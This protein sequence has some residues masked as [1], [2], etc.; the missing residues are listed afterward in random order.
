MPIG[1]VS[2]I[3]YLASKNANVNLDAP[4]VNLVPW[5]SI[6][7][8]L[9]PTAANIRVNLDPNDMLIFDA[10]IE[11]LQSKVANSDVIGFREIV[12]DMD[13]WVEEND[14]QNFLL[15]SFITVLQGM[16][17]GLQ[18]VPRVSPICG[19]VK[20]LHA[21]KQ[22]RYLEFGHVQLSNIQR[23]CTI[24]TVGNL[25]PKS[26][27]STVEGDWF[28][29]SDRVYYDQRSANYTLPGMWTHRL[30]DGRRLFV[31]HR[32]STSATQGIP[33]KLHLDGSENCPDLED[34][35]PSLAT[36]INRVS[37][38]LDLPVHDG[39]KQYKPEVIR[40]TV[41][42]FGAS[43]ILCHKPRHHI[44]DSFQSRWNR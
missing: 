27:R 39:M 29:R 17:A 7:G 15:K 20:I 42:S 16:A 12:E 5:Q 13:S 25:I 6:E 40:V 34:K 4:N 36:E 21:P 19:E 18:I 14:I 1:G 38:L 11:D 33:F 3:Q 2:V 10:F 43:P 41:D 22:T 37:P 26:T 24:F 9:G 23:R 31:T 28:W 8:Y 30:F 44:V 32:G 35:G